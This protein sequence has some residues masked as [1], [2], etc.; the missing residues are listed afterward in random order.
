[1]CC[2]TLQDLNDENV[3]ETVDFSEFE[4]LFQVKKAMKKESKRKGWS[5]LH[6]VRTRR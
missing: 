1:M 5:E 3:M 2:L 4:R 6:T